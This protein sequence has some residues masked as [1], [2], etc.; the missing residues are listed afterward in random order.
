MMVC[1]YK[2]GFSSIKRKKL[3][4]DPAEVKD[5]VRLFIANGELVFCNLEAGI[6]SFIK[7]KR[8]TPIYMILEIIRWS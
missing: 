4:K 2:N 5:E 3:K 1:D 6:M 7:D 8:H